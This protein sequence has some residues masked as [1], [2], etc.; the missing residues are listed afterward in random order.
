MSI[1]WTKLYHFCWNQLSNFMQN[2]RFWV[3]SK[4]GKWG[5]ALKGERDSF[6]L[7]WFMTFLGWIWMRFDDIYISYTLG[8]PYGQHRVIFVK[9]TLKIHVKYKTSGTLSAQEMGWCD[10]LSDIHCCLNIFQPSSDVWAWLEELWT[11]YMN[12]LWSTPCNFCQNQLSKN[13]M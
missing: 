8:A 9:T 7:E 5:A 4:Q 13:F 3:P 2:I 12:T 1:L 10:T 6:P 11:G